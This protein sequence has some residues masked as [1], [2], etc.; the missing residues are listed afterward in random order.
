LFSGWTIWRNSSCVQWSLFFLCFLPPLAEG[1]CKPKVQVQ[2]ALWS[3]C[4]PGISSLSHQQKWSLSDD[5]VQQDRWPASKIVVCVCVILHIS[6]WR[7]G[8]NVT[9]FWCINDECNLYVWFCITCHEDMD[10]L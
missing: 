7:Y 1:S 6:S 3:H 4:K 9:F 2:E 8:R 5:H 10:A